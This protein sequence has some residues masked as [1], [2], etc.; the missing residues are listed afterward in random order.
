MPWHIRISK[1]HHGILQY[2]KITMGYYDVRITSWNIKVHQSH[3]RPEVPRGF[4]EVK[5]PRLCDKGPGWWL[6]CQPC[7]PAAFYPQELLLVLISIRG[8]QPQGHSAIGRIMSKKNSNTP[9]GIEPATFRFVAQRLNHCTT[10]VPNHGILPCLK[11]TMG[12]YNVITTK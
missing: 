12:F 1:N 4:Q 10:V 7:A 2:Q 3:Y 8:C 9:S 11:A 5:V 6:G